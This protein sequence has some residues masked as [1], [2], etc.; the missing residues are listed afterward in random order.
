MIEFL[1]LLLSTDWFLPHWTEIGIELPEATRACI[2]QG[3]R[4][5]IDQMTGTDDGTFVR[6]FSESI[7]QVVES[8]FLALL[9]RCGAEPEL[10][11]TR[12]EWAKLS[13]GE[14]TAV[15]LCAMFNRDIPAADG[16]DVAPQLDFPIRAEV[17]RA[18]EGYALNPSVFRDC[19]LSSQTAWDIRTRKLLASPRT[20][21]NQLWR[22]LLDHRLRAFW[23]DL[24]QRLTEQQLRELASWYR[25]MIKTASHENAAIDLPSYM[26]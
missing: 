14:L 2:Q 25:A 12:K 18:W 21:V 7:R 24:H 10:L 4:V 19:C 6:S 16:S 13:H 23:V 22:V 11:A 5:I 8:K 26:A 1:V 20:L 3:C 9:V 15:F 17:V